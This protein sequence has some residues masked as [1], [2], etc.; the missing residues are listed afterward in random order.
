[1]YNSEIK[2]EIEI[3]RLNLHKALTLAEISAKYEVDAAEIERLTVKHKNEVCSKR[4]HWGYGEK[5]ETCLNIVRKYYGKFSDE[6]VKS[7][8]EGAANLS[9]TSQIN[10][11]FRE[12][13][14]RLRLK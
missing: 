5:T 1:M 2:R 3:A 10:L 9:G 14:K 12:A 7:M 4:V 13:K 6:V 8:L 11:A